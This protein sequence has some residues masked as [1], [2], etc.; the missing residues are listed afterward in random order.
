MDWQYL[1]PNVLGRT[2]FLRCLTLMLLM[3]TAAKLSHCVSY[4]VQIMELDVYVLSKPIVS[5][6]HVPFRGYYYSCVVI[7]GGWDV[8]S[9]FLWHPLIVELIKFLIYRGSTTSIAERHS[10]TFPSTVQHSL[11]ISLPGS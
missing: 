5:Q 4:H 6:P 7:L 1:F 10:E 11:H 3:L 9:V 8:T 2:V